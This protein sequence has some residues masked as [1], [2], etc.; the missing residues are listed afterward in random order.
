MYVCVKGILIWRGC[1]SFLICQVSVVCGTYS[2]CQWKVYCS[3]DKPCR[4]RSLL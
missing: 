3:K 1:F 2:N 4:E